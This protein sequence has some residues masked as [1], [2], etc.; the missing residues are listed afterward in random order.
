MKNL[1]H[2]LSSYRYKY[3]EREKSILN[4]RKKYTEYVE[5]FAEKVIDLEQEFEKR[6]QIFIKKAKQELKDEEKLEIKSA[7]IPKDLTVTDAIKTF[8]MSF[9]RYPKNMQEVIDFFKNRRL[10]KKLPEKSE[11]TV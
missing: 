5:N 10:N 9:D 6:K 11:I 1:Y 7:A 4:D 3:D 8:K 2:E